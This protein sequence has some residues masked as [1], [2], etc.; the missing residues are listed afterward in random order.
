MCEERSDAITSQEVDALFEYFVTDDKSASQNEDFYVIRRF[1][2]DRVETLRQ[3]AEREM[4]LDCRY[5]DCWS[6]LG[7][8]EGKKELRERMEA[9]KKREGI[10]EENPRKLNRKYRI[11]KERRPKDGIF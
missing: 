9:I 7:T 8:T 6:C 1:T 4:C 11:P 3:I 10:S 2:E 5:T